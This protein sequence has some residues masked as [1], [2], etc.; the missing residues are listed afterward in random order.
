[1]PTGLVPENSTGGGVS[2]VLYEPDPAVASV[3]PNPAD[4]WAK[5]RA[6]RAAAAPVALDVQLGAVAAL[7]DGQRVEVTDSTRAAL[8][9]AIT[10]TAG[11]GTTI[12]GAASYAFTSNG[13]SASFDYDAANTNWVMV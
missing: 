5:V 13:Q 12:M 10:V 6:N 1:M 3:A 11:A 7:A 2:W 8:V 9:A 4:A